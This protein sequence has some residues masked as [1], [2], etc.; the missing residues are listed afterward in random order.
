MEWRRVLVPGGHLLVFI[1]WR[2]EAA[3][4]GAIE[5]ADLRHIGLLVWDKTF[6]GMGSCFRNQHELILHFTKGKGLS[7]QRKDT[8]NVLHYKPV[9]GGEHPTEKPVDLLERLISVVCKEGGIV[10]DSFAGSGTTAV[11]A[12]RLN[13]DAILIELNPR[14]C[15]MARRRIKRAY[16]MF[17][18]IRCP[19]LCTTES[20]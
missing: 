19:D 7:P 12:A 5:S 6:F 20:R 15:E 11:A 2:M 14:Y 4:S 17:V 1:D 8:G 10:L 3:L 16:G 18:D 9:R 13:R